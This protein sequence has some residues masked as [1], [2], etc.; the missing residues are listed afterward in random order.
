[1]M[2]SIP[3]S[4][5]NAW[6]VLTL[7]LVPIGGG[8]PAGVLLAHNRGFGWIAMSILYFVSDVILAC[9]FEPLMLLAVAGAKRSAFLTRIRE[10][11]AKSTRRSIASY[12]NRLTPLRLVLISFGVDPMTGRSAAAIAGHG[13]VAGWALAIAGDMV[14][15]ALLMVSTLFLDNVLGDG[16][17]TTVAILVLMTVVPAIVRRFRKKAGTL[18]DPG[19][20]GALK[21]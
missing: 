13:F 4:A 10:H 7:F 6:A 5:A 21:E 9:V 17:W 12:G 14:F 18:S 19:S 1:M 20:R 8:I 15:F 16:T 2:T 3:Q 11:F